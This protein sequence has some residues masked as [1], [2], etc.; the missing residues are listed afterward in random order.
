MDTPQFLKRGCVPTVCCQ[1]NA[2]TG[3][4]DQSQ[5]RLKCKS[6]EQQQHTQKVLNRRSLTPNECRQKHLIL[7]FS[8]YQKFTSLG[9][10]CP[11]S[12]IVPQFHKISGKSQKA[13]FWKEWLNY[14]TDTNSPQLQA[15]LWVDLFDEQPT[16]SLYDIRSAS[17]RAL[18]NLTNEK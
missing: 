11:K 2:Y 8:V 5:E 3:L 10:K 18:D 7:P 6:L 16:I 15:R 14:M 17:L 9:G 12:Q 1:L 4:T 13:A